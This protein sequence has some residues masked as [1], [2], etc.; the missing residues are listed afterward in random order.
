MSLETH[1]GELAISERAALSVKPLEDTV[2]LRV[3][4]NQICIKLLGKV[5]HPGLTGIVDPSSSEINYALSSAQRLAPGLSSHPVT[6]FKE[7]ASVSF[8]RNIVSSGETSEPSPDD[9]DID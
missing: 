9:Y 6:R 7:N 8:G 5:V 2:T 1:I 3:L 4:L